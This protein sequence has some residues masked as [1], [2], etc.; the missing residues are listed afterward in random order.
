MCVHLGVNSLAM[1]GGQS[2]QNAVYQIHS[3]GPFLPTVEW[4]FIFLPI[5]FHMIVGVVI[6][7]YM[8]PNVSNYPYAGNWRYIMQRVTG[9]LAAVFILFHVLHLH[10]WVHFDPWLEWLEK[11]GFGRFKPYNAAST[12]AEAIQASPIVLILYAIGMLSCVYHFAN[13]LW[14][15]GITWGV[16]VSP[17]AQQY[18]TIICLVI[19][20]ALGGAG[21][22]SLVGLQTMDVQKARET[23]N[24]M[25][26]QRVDDGSI[27]EDE[28]KLVGP[29]TEGV[30]MNTGQ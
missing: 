20:I 27:L 8:K 23:E 10:G 28:H 16:W 21:M 26:E 4:L 5:I 9:I 29:E 14:T 11:M 30:S 25:Y 2:F 19:G 6:I 15:M 1:I 3:L 24:H 17:K 7:R 13:G 22:A 12:A 18:G